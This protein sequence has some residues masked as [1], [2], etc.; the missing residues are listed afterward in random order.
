MNNEMKNAFDHIH[1]EGELKVRTQKYVFEKMQRKKEKRSYSYRRMA[2]V[3]ACFFFVLLG[4]GGYVSF[5]MPTSA[6]SIDVNPSLE[7]GINRFD[8]VLSVKGYNDDG[9]AVASALNIRF[10]KYTDA[11]KQILKDESMEAYLAKDSEVSITVLGKTAEKQEEMLTNVSSC[12][13]SLHEN[14]Q[15]SHGDKEEVSK[16]HEAGV[17]FGK[18]K[19]FLELREIKT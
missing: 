10:L 1:A 8:R 18:Y 17:S 3:M 11:V 4:T 2:V 12:T 19:A 15:C 16:A 7:L 5:F 9:R 13:M 14:V 6:I